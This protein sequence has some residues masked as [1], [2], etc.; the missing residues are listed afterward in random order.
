MREQSVALEYQTE[1]ALVDR[2]LRHVL[3]VQCKG[4]ALRVNKSCNHAQR[5]G[6]TA[7]AR[8]EK[9]NELTFLD[10]KI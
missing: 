5:C 4:A 10:L 3:A 1:L 8:S 9:G 7:S 2:N 6:F